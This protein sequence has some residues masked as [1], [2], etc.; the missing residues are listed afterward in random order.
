MNECI[1]MMVAD[2]SMEE[3][4]ATEHCRGLCEQFE[5]LFFHRDFATWNSQHSAIV[6]TMRSVISTKGRGSLMRY[7]WHSV[8]CLAFNKEVAEYISDNYPVLFRHSIPEK[9]IVS[10]MDDFEKL[11]PRNGEPD[12]QNSFETLIHQRCSFQ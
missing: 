1:I 6:R 11:R 12:K 3:K 8:M 5:A 9:T 10:L 7:P 4:K 2:E